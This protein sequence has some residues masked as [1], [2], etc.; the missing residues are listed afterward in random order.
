MVALSHRLA[1]FCCWNANVVVIRALRIAAGLLLIGVAVS[2]DIAVAEL[3]AP[4]APT[5]TIAFDLPAQPLVSAIERYSVISGWQVIYDADLATGRRSTRVHGD[6]TPAAALRA[7]LVGTGLKPEYV[8]AD[9]VMLILYRANGA[10]QEVP[11]ERRFNAYYGLI[12]T[13]LVRILC[14]APQIRS[15]GHRVAVGFW[16]G[17]SGAVTRAELLGSTGKPELDQAFDQAIRKL[18][19]GEAPPA[20]FEQ[21]VVLLVTPDLIS[22]C[23]PPAN[24]LQPV[25]AEQ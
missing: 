20:G 6:F 5:R 7:L 1:R 18:S 24:R 12:Q 2:H 13:G 10:R 25:R 19:V 21:P 11:V 9:S 22:D 14:E 4:V 17:S 23:G 3:S 16:I 8:A 15:G